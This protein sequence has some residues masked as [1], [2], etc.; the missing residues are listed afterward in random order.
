[1]SGLCACTLVSAAQVQQVEAALFA[2]GMPV[3]ALMEKAGLRLAAAIAADYPAGRY[4]RVGV[5]VGPGHN[6]GDALVVARELWLAGRAVQVF[7]PRPPT[8]PLARTHLD[9]FQSLGGKVHTGAV[10]EE[11]GVDL[12]VDGLFGF[13]LERSVAEP[14]AGLMAQVNASGV[15]VAAVDLPSGL[16]SETGE[17]LGGLAVRAARTYCLGLWKRGLWQDAAL[18]WLG[19]PVR[20]DIG[21]AEAQVRSV[22]GEDHRSARLLLPDAARAGLPLARPATAHKYSVGTLLAVA[23]SRQYGGAATL[24]ALGARSGGPGMLYL[25]L[26]ESL[27][28]RVAARLPEA[29]VYSCPQAENGA[30]ADLAGVD[31]K[32]FDAVVCGPGLGKADQALVLR[33]ARE[34]AGALVLDADGLNLIAGQLEVL[35]QR[36]A[37]TVLTPHPGEF[38]R[39]FPDIALA[40][41]QG[42][43]RT[44]ALRSHAWIVLKGARTVVASPSGQVWVNPGGSPA[45]AR[46]GSGDVLAGLL[47]ALLAQCENPEPAVLG[48]VWWHAAAG[49][50]LA[51]RHTVLGVDAETLALGLLP[52]LAADSR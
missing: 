24:V 20:L 36:A 4:P 39:L 25:A 7:C 27:A 41:R 29:I 34:A 38:K 3:E 23:G 50:W 17:A 46:G 16:S 48:A 44:A 26:P 45:L 5:L 19:V 30:L 15:P 22:L 43:A 33:L 42:A 12:W 35:A 14:Y 31:L 49:E 9:Y 51:D 37:P 32:K 13:G 40:D 6:G 10:P 28:D 2:A 21:F 8:K 47:G 1:M 11:P 18:D 52:F